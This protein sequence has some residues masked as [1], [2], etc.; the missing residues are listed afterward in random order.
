MLE[1]SRLVR[2]KVLIKP[3]RVAGLVHD[4]GSPVLWGVFPLSLLLCL[5]V[6][7]GSDSAITTTKRKAIEDAGETASSFESQGTH[8]A[9]TDTEDRLKE[10]SQLLVRHDKDW[11][12][13]LDALKR[14]IDDPAFEQPKTSIGTV[15]CR[16]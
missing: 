14:I 12:R 15:L 10:L 7:C 3:A 16:C 2:E 5:A 6:S 13:Q 4:F 1:S 9:R 11:I 8:S